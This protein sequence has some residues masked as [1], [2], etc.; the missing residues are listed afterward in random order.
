MNLKI[1]ELTTYQHKIYY[2]F[3]TNISG[4]FFFLP[5]LI[6]RP[7]YETWKFTLA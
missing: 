5:V 3:T 1:Q 7:N 2:K 6:Q 4:T